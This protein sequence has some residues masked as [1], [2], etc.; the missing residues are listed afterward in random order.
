MHCSAGL[1]LVKFRTGRVFGRAV[2]GA[3]A[4]LAQPAR[5]RRAPASQRRVAFLFTSLIPPA[6][7]CSQ[8]LAC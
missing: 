1:K 4:G 6:V 8:A 7:T 5:S 2:T 3:S